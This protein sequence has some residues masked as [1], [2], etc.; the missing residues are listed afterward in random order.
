MSDVEILR[1]V[2]GN[3][4]LKVPKDVSAFGLSKVPVAIER[5]HGLQA[6][7]F[8]K[9]TALYAA[10][11][12]VTAGLY[13]LSPEPHGR[14]FCG[15]TVHLGRRLSFPLN[16]DSMEFIDD[17][18]LPSSLLRPG[19]ER[20]ERPIFVASAAIPTH[21][22]IRSGLWRLA[23]AHIYNTL[24]A[25]PAFYDH[26]AK[27]HPPI[28]WL[29]Y[30]KYC[31][32]AYVSYIALN[33]IIVLSALLLF[34]WLTTKSWK[35][36]GITIAFA[37]LLLANDVVKAFFWSPHTQMF[38][39][40]VP[41]GAVLLCEAF[42]RVPNRSMAS[43][44]KI[45]IVT[46][47][48]TLAYGSFPV[49]LLAGILGLTVRL[50]SKEAR[51]SLVRFAG[52]TLA[53]V[54]GLALPSVIWIAV[55][56][57]KTGGYHN[58]ELALYHQFVWV[59]ESA[60]LG[61]SQL[62]LASTSNLIKFFEVLLPVSYFPVLLLVGIALSG[63]ALRVPIGLVIRERSTTFTAIALST[64]VCLIYFYLLGTYRERLAIN[65]VLPLLVAAAVLAL[66]IVE[67]VARPFPAVMVVLSVWILTL[68]R[69]AYE[70]GKAGP[71]SS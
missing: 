49:W 21:L 42:L 43:M 13:L 67:K 28:D 19:N 14:Y 6:R 34:N 50:F 62:L 33:G 22:L 35:P 46:G 5:A 12:A 45:G 71:W 23:P 40:V 52:Q 15:E 1:D 47:L 7:N 39:L 3:R 54:M 32:C 17:A 60:R 20:Q 38:N 31:L 61:W 63:V 59:W 8:I 56:E 57:L 24:A 70:I 25:S 65:V 41:L 4:Q 64:L 18:I 37:S 9:V 36:N 2:P 11:L 29:K 68:A 10:I 30:P 69:F 55:C 66:G 44:L 53:L 27:H 51:I 16:C 48:L 26:Y 58:R